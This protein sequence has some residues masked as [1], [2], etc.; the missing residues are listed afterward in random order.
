MSRPSLITI[1]GPA[2]SGK[3]TLGE[4]LARR[5]GYTFF[6]T[7]VMYRAVTL[8]AL[9]QQ[10]DCSDAG[11]MEHLARAIR[12]DVLS[13]TKTEDGGDGRPYTVLVDMQDVTWSI[14]SAEVDR[15]VSLVS[16][17]AGVRTELIC[18]QRSIGQRG[19]M[20]M[21]GRDIGTVV[22]PDAPMKIYLETSLK[23]RARRRLADLQS[24]APKDPDLSLEQVEA[25]LSRRDAL[26]RH[27]LFPANDALI[28]HT[29]TCSPA[30]EVERIIALFDGGNVPMSRPET[31]GG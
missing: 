20:V 11:A 26:D 4:L 9:Q 2:A 5:L 30:E 1:D 21:V 3:S 15:H 17:H 6:D 22:F 12:I 19:R 28:I 16:C 14:R 23:E 7:G 29:D 10:L 27:V 13:P 8:S 24:K 31:P 25:D 18:Q